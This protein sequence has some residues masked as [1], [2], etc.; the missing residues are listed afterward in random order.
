MV[1]IEKDEDWKVIPIEEEHQVGMAR[2]LAKKCARLIRFEETKISLIVTSVSELARNILVHAGKGTVTFRIVSRGEKRGLEIVFADQGP[3]IE[4]IARV[5]RGDYS[6]N[7]SLGIGVSGAKR[8]MDELEIESEP[9]KGTR[10]WARKW[11]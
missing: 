3:G 8:M 5:L 2:R 11:L 4:D 9:G 6:T 10:I 7:G 1:N